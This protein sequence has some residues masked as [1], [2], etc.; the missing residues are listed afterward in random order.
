M[1]CRQCGSH[2]EFDPFHGESRRRWLQFLV[3]AAL[4]E[5]LAIVL[6]VLAIE[7]WPWWLAT[8]GLFVLS[9]ALLK[10]HDSRWVICRHCGESYTHW[11]RAGP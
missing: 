4:L 9:Q 1:R 6:L 7:I 5:S 3:L 11:G 10:W 8:A 2:I